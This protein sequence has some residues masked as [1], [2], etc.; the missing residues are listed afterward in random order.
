VVKNLVKGM[1]VASLLNATFTGHCCW[2]SRRNGDKQRRRRRGRRGRDL[3]IW[4]FEDL[5][6]WR[7]GFS[8]EF[9]I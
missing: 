1:A 8:L 9:G 6:I 5:G 4:G 3:E 2:E 7:F